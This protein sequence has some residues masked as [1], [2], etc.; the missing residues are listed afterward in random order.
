ML[1]PILSWYEG[2]TITSL[3]KMLKFSNNIWQVVR[4]WHRQLTHL[5]IHIDVSRKCFV[6]ICQ[7]SKCHNFLIFQLIFI[8]F[9]LFCSKMFTLS[10]EIKLN[11]FQISPLRQKMLFLLGNPWALVE[12]V[13][14]VYS[15]TCVTKY[16]YCHICYVPENEWIDR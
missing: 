14:P 4:L 10:S 6:K 5:H 11:L 15:H 9:S 1:T 8:K 7:T 16:C 2:H 13:F 3:G 12:F